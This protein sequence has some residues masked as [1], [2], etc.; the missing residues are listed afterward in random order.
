[1]RISMSRFSNGIAALTLVV[2]LL[3]SCSEDSSYGSRTYSFGFDNFSMTTSSTQDIGGMKSLGKIETYMRSK[4]CPI[5]MVDFESL[6]AAKQAFK[7]GTSKLSKSE[8]D[9]L[10]DPSTKLSFDYIMTGG[11]AAEK[12]SYSNR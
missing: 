9:A 1:M 3:V 8:M 6:D 4:G 2:M 10:I 12:Y 5:G 7:N 11:D